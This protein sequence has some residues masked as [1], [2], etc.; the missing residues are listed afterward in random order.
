MAL[1]ECIVLEVAPS[2]EME[3]LL[4][5]NIIFQDLV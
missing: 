1:R 5:G 4:E 2:G 3:I